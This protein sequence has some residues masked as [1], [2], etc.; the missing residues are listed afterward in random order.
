M[1]VF[2]VLQKSVYR[3]REEKKCFVFSW[4]ERISSA[5]TQLDA[6]ERHERERESSRGVKCGC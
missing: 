2:V 5:V 4:F 6:L 1:I 3:K